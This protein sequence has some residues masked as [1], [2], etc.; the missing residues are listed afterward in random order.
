M[1]SI[2]I[3]IPAVEQMYARVLVNWLQLDP[4]PKD[5]PMKVEYGN[6]IAGA[7]DKMARWFLEET[8]ADV[9]LTLE[10]DHLYPRNLLE[11]VANYDMENFPIIGSLYYTRYEPYQP[12]P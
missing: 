1:N 8:D 3:A 4:S 7:Y 9:L 2:A 6:V 12:V 11:R 5:C 10:I